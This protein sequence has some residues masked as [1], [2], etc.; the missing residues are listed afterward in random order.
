MS[1]SRGIAAALRNVSRLSGSRL[2][3]ISVALTLGASLTATLVTGAAADSSIANRKPAG[4]LGVTGTPA[5]PG[6]LTAVPATAPSQRRPLTVVVVLPTGDRV[7]V[8]VAPDG[9]QVATPI[10][11]VSAGG[12]LRAQS[13]FMRFSWQGDQYVIPDLAVSYLHSVL[14]PR[15]FDVSYLA[16]LAVEGSAGIPVRIAFTSASAAA[17]VL[18]GRITIRSGSL[19]TGTITP[20]QARRL[21]Q[22]LAAQWQ[23]AD[24]RRSRV[25]VGQLPGIETISL[26]STAGDAPLPASPTQLQARASAVAS[27]LP[28]YTLTL[29]AIDLNGNPGTFAGIVQNVGDDTLFDQETNLLDSSATGSE[30]LSVPRGTYSLEVSVVT[31]DPSGIGFDTAL[32]IKPQVTVDAN[33][34]VTLDARTAVPYQAELDTTVNATQ[35]TDALSFWRTSAAGGGNGSVGEDIFLGLFSFSPN[36]YPSIV[37]DRLLATPTVAV[38]KGSLLFDASTGLQDSGTQGTDPMYVLDFPHEKSVPSSLTF[39]VLSADLTPVYQQLYEPPSGCPQLGLEGDSTEVYL[40]LGDGQWG[41]LE[42]VSGVSVPTGDRT[43]YWYSGDPRLDLWQASSGCT[44][45]DW[46]YDTIRPIVAGRSIS[47]VWH[48]AP[49]APS[50]LAPQPYGSISAGTGDPRLSV[51]PACRQDDNGMLNLLR[52]GD[53]DRSHSSIDVD[54]YVSS[55][56]YDAVSFYRNGTLAL[57]SAALPLPDPLIPFGLDLPLLPQAAT[58]QLDWTEGRTGDSAAT[59]DTDWTFRSSPADPAAA[60]P[61]TEQCAPDASW[62]CSFLPLLFL[63]Y[64]LALNYGDQATASTLEQIDFAV[65]EQE[66]SPA[67]AGLSATVSASFDDGQTWTAPQNAASLGSG[68]FTTTVQQPPLASTTGFVS[69]RVTAHDGSGDAVTQ[70][71]IRA[72]GLT[73]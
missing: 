34:T 15:L 29:D 62:S 67:P 26:A 42:P 32:V 50:P 72:Y 71:I 16:R 45:G 4:T 38:T 23:L 58:Y 35:R 6:S 37:A 25:P 9:E 8:D 46:L 49:V 59:I 70:T 7:R 55:T 27:G 65:I 14:D 21:G 2:R 5:V 3:V 17:G 36:T 43:D 12:V 44:V 18:G 47:E 64:N 33:T 13:T 73:S 57:T 10:P 68:Q 54:A 24:A 11:A 41:A 53:S 40:P 22:L 66:N 1:R 61:A 63:S 56:S 19:A 30:S 52:F 48:K 51:C 31:P 60:L 69:L 39:T 28:S 20:R